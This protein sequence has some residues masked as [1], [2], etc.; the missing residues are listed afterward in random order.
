[1][2][3]PAVEAA[4]ALGDRLA[5]ALLAHDRAGGPRGFDRV[6]RALVR[7]TT[8][9]DLD[10]VVQAAVKLN[11]LVQDTWAE[12]T[13]AACKQ[14]KLYHRAWLRGLVAGAAE[15]GI[16]GTDLAR[17]IAG[18]TVPVAY[19]E[20]I[21]LPVYAYSIGYGFGQAWAAV[22]RKEVDRQEWLA[23]L[24][25]GVEEAEEKLRYAASY[26]HVELDPDLVPGD[27]RSGRNAESGFHLGTLAG[28]F[29]R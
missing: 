8:P 26:H 21:P 2:P 13:K 6:A 10:A 4:A 1:M 16:P 27:G 28:I 22:S 14:R 18:A 12:D 24:R 7:E 29:T 25:T 5:A 3:D 19:E 20:A 23:A 9:V 17:G 15:A 11:H